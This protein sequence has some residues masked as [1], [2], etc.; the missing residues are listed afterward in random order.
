MDTKVFRATMFRRKFVEN[1]KKNSSSRHV[2]NCVRSSI[3]TRWSNFQINSLCTLFCRWQT[4]IERKVDISLAFSRK[5]HFSFIL[6][7]NNNVNDLIICYFVVLF[8]TVVSL[9]FVCLSFAILCLRKSRNIKS[10]VK[11]SMLK[12][13]IR[14]LYTKLMDNDPSFSRKS[15]L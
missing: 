3:V 6:F 1:L 7:N 8:S 11:Y 12:R 4:A 13:N 15:K 2:C 14:E 9:A 10:I 5:S